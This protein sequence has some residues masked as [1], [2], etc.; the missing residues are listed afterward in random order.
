MTKH[1]ECNEKPSSYVVQQDV[2][3]RKRFPK[4]FS[5]LHFQYKVI[6]FSNDFIY[7]YNVKM[8]KDN[9]Q[10]CFLTTEK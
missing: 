9:E 5:K 4:Y 6:E 8:I 3:R 7:K 1:I 2:D 10:D